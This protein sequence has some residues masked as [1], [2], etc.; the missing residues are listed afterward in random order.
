MALART[1]TVSGLTMP[2]DKIFWILFCVS[3]ATQL[4]ISSVIASGFGDEVS[5]VDVGLV[6]VSGGRQKRRQEGKA[7]LGPERIGDVQLDDVRLLVGFQFALQVAEGGSKLLL[8][9]RKPQHLGHLLLRIA[10]CAGVEHGQAGGDAV[11]REEQV[12][13][14]GRQLPIE[15]QGEGRVAGN[16]GLDLGGSGHWRRHEDQAHQNAQDSFQGSSSL[17]DEG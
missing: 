2:G 6:L 14:V 10:A 12:A 5:L 9:C 11:R 16:E 3:C 1:S 17:A 4:L 8:I 13:R 7:F 15:V